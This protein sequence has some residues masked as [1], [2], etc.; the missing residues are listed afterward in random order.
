M[1]DEHTERD[2]WRCYDDPYYRRAERHQTVV[3]VEDDGWIEVA[4]E[5]GSGY[6]RES[7]RT[8][9][10][11]SVVDWLVAERIMGIAAG[12]IALGEWARRCAERQ[13]PPPVCRWCGC[14]GFL[15]HYYGCSRPT[16]A[17]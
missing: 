3:S 1:S 14:E 6:Q 11:P 8:F 16:G 9:L 17:Q 7:I 2:G 12:I 5:E 15:S 4:A 10:P 13:T